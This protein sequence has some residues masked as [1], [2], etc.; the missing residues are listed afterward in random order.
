[1]P[2]L[3]FVDSVDKEARLDFLGLAK[4]V[5]VLYK[6]EKNAISDKLYQFEH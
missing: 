2:N 6:I 3:E 4:F 5:Q 1:M